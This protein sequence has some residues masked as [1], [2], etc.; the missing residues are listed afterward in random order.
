MFLVVIF[1]VELQIISDPAVRLLM[2]AVHADS[3]LA[4]A[5]W[6]GRLGEDPA[7]TG[8]NQSLDTMSTALCSFWLH[9]TLG[10]GRAYRSLVSGAHVSA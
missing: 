9:W 5:V 8:P 7:M 1:T 2:P 6:A 10:T 4:A 3:E